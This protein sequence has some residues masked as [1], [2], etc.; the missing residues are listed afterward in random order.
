[1]LTLLSIYVKSKT[2]FN[3]AFKTIKVL[4]SGI[5]QKKKKIGIADNNV[6]FYTQMLIVNIY[7]EDRNEMFLRGFKIE[8]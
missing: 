8:F 1:M 7:C 2:M 3:L 4:T 5:S 6:Y